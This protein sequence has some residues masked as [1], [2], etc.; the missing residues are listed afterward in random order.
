VQSV[1]QM[2]VLC[3][4]CGDR[5]TFSRVWALAPPGFRHFA[6][7]GQVDFPCGH[8]GVMTQ[9]QPPNDAGTL[10]VQAPGDVGIHI[11][12]YFDAGVTQALTEDDEGDA[13]LQRGHDI[14]V[15]QVVEADAG[16]AE[17]SGAPHEPLVDGIHGAG[18]DEGNCWISINGR[19]YRA[20][21]PEARGT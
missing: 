21:K 4:V 3:P 8:I 1:T 20:Y 17:E 14:A 13:G 5:G 19:L 10:P 7:I 18:E 11:S 12:G 16:Q 15:P 6:D 9:Q 2:P